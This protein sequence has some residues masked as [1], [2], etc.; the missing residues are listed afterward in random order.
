MCKKKNMGWGLQNYKSFMIALGREFYA[1]LEIKQM[2]S[3]VMKNKMLM[4]KKGLFKNWF[5]T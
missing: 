4:M 1:L 3:V 5:E 2:N